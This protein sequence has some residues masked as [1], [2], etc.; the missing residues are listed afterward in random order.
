MSFKVKFYNVAK[1]KNS[2]Y[3]PEES[4]QSR[5]FDCSVKEN[6]SIIEPVLIIQ[7]E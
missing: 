1:R 7:S 4:T 2:T 5:D 3:K 6:T